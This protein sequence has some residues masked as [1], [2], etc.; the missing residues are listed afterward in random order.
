MD[1]LS[2]DVRF[3]PVRTFSQEKCTARWTK[4]HAA[5][6][7][8]WV[9]SGAFTQERIR[10]DGWIKDDVCQTRGVLGRGLHRPH[11]CR[12]WRGVR[13]DLTDEVTTYEQMAKTTDTGA[14]MLCVRG[15]GCILWKLNRVR[16]WEQ[17]LVP[18]CS[19]SRG[20]EEWRRVP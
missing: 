19:M 12:H 18:H 16:K 5:I 4:K 20:S 15:I 7:R 10:G 14:K 6:G 13:R 9:A 17:Q 11:E 1:E 8:S 2:V 3:E